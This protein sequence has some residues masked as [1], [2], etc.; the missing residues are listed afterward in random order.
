MGINLTGVRIEP[1]HLDVVKVNVNPALGFGPSGT[2]V[3]PV[4]QML[5]SVGV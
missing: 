5:A 2:P 4:M 1:V 3:A